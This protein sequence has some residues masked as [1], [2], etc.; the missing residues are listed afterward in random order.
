MKKRVIALYLP[1]FHPIP[2]NDLWWGRGFTEW[3]NV[4]KAQ[5]LFRGHYQPRVP[6]DLG[7]YDLRLPEVREA[8]ADLA[9]E[10]GIEGF[11]YYHYW[12]GVGKQLL[13]MPFNEVVSS[14][15]PNF[16]FCLCWANHSW[17]NRTWDVNASKVKPQLLMKQEYGG[18][19][20]YKVHFGS[21]L[22]AF[23]DDRYM[24]IDDRLIF[25]IYDPFAFSD[26]TNFINTWRDL[27][28]N[29]GIRDFYFIAMVP[30]VLNT[31]VGES[32]KREYAKPDLESSASLYKS[33]LDLGFDGINSFGKRRGEILSKGYLRDT[34]NLILKR[35]NIENVVKKY[36][37][38]KTVAGFFPPEDAWENVFPTV[39]PQWDRTARVGKAEGIYVNSTPEKFKKHVQKAFELLKNKA[40]E[41][42]IVFIK[43]WNEWA[44]GNYME[45]D[46]KFGHG[47]IDV[48]REAIEES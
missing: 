46:L 43:S 22:P 41:H 45:P 36:D 24:T 1:Q 31:K 12:F 32:G 34:L 35:F 28:K 29:N 21:L 27:A 42:Q 4:G 19:D 38:E 37:Y 18:Y 3:T 26:V 48:L 40:D 30:A 13:E 2:E 9:R 39:L 8:Q 44:E 25:L 7:Y 47:Y 23:R 10:A 14:G 11:C 20:D 5:P 16:P 15:K 17:T 6:A 33:V